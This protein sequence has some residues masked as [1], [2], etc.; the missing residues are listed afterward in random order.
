M[1]FKEPLAPVGGAPLVNSKNLFI[2]GKPACGKTTLVKEIGYK[3]L[4]KVGGFYTE[5][6]SEGGKRAGFILK[7][8]DG[9]EGIL[10]KK[11]MQSSYKLN[12]YGIDL[13][14]LENLAIGSL[15]DALSK[16]KTI[17]IDE[18]GSMEIISQR[19]RQAV[20]EALGS[21]SRVLATIRYKSQ[22]FTDEVKKI[23][24]TQ[25]LYL[26]RDNYLEIKSYVL[27]WIK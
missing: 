10:A 3:Y 5:E 8:F 2:T 7:T 22:P 23:E 16:N 19:F 12:K 20:M 26:S 27:E 15:D 6:I 9:K 4:E 21:M 11:G 14:V 24:D 25:M 18:I 1:L 13:G 17:I